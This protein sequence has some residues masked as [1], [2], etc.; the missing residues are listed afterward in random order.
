MHPVP[1]PPSLRFASAY[2]PPNG[3]GGRL[4]RPSASTILAG[5]IRYCMII[6]LLSGP[7]VASAEIY[8]WVDQD[9]RVH[10]SDRREIGAQRVP[11]QSRAAPDTLRPVSPEPDSPDTL[12]L[13]SYSSLEIVTPKANAT[14][15]EQ[16]GGI[17]VSLM[18]SP[19]VI[20]GQQMSV[21]LDEV[22][23]PVKAG[24][25]QFRLTGASLGTH[26]L[27]IRIKGSDGHTVAQSAPLRFHVQQPEEPGQLR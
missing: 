7:C 13:G 17:P 1:S 16:D 14:L 12:F 21:L 18:V 8:R 5:M 11:I 19:P 27:Q 22:A 3:G 10:F 4:F 6:A 9:G 24:A 20:E 23:L 2:L 15:T 25:T 26:R